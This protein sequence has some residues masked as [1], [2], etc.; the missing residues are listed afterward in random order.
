MNSCIF[1]QLKINNY[2][3]V[4]TRTGKILTLNELDYY[5]THLKIINTVFPFNMTE[6]EIFVVAH[7]LTMKGD[8]REDLFGT[9]SR[10]LV[11]TRCNLTLAGLSNYLNA[12][13]LK[14]CIIEDENKKLKL[15]QLLNINSEAHEYNL[16][17]Q[18]K[19]T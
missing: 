3:N 11:R 18:L 2:V 15:H 13:Q 1:V 19:T 8:I 6:K 12:L 5:I 16:T 7:F 4:M 17:L 10:K 9:T 14:R